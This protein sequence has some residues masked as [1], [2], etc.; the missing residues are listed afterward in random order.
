MKA[1]LTRKVTLCLTILRAMKLY[2]GRR[3]KTSSN[4]DTGNEREW[5]VSRSASL[6][7]V[8][9]APSTR[10]IGIRELLWTYGEEATPPPTGNET[11]IVLPI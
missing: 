10:S 9:K 3:G 5:L 2:S 1:M 6:T 7:L 8:G 11:P 4:I